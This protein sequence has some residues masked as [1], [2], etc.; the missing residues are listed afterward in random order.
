MWLDNIGK[1]ILN[2]LGLCLFNPDF[3]VECIGC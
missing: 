2:M 3:A 1:K